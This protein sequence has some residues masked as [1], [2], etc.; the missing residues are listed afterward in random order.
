M[1]SPIQSS[2]SDAEVFIP[3][4][5]TCLIKAQSELERFMRDWE[6]RMGQHRSRLLRVPVE[7]EVIQL[8]KHHERAQEEEG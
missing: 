8:W 7:V 2:Q 5:Y 1:N 6:I 4:L 3:Y